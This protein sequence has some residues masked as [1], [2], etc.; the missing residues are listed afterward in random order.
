MRK[1]MGERGI[2]RTISKSVV[3]RYWLTVDMCKRN[4]HVGEGVW[5]VV[6]KNQS[7]CASQM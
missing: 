3:E 4:V 5:D 6:L 7:L 2:L 1:V